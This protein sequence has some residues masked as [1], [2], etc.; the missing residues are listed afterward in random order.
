MKRGKSY[1]QNRSR[2]KKGMVGGRLPLLLALGGLIM[3]VISAILIKNYSQPENPDVLL[4]VSGAPRLKVDRKELDF[5]D[6]RVGQVVEA[7]FTLANVGDQPLQFSQPPY[8]ELAAG[9]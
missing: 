9:C 7:S 2:R 6:V 8:V 5:G 3:I 1:R 4:E